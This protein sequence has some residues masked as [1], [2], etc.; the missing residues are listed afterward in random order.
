MIRP[1]LKVPQGLSIPEC[2]G[3]PSEALGRGSGR[4]AGSPSEALG[5]GGGREVGSPSEAL[6]RGSGQE[7]KS[8]RR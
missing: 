7:G 1:H 4:E 8:P 5:R 6:G 3:S 2:A